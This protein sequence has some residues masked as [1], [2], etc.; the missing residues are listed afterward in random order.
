MQED[1]TLFDSSNSFARPSTSTQTASMGI[2]ND[3][4]SSEFTINQEIHPKH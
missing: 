3:N 1:D 4:L 2:N